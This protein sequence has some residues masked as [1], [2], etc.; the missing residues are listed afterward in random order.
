[1]KILVDADACPVKEIIVSLAKKNNLKVIMF[2]DTSHILSDD[3]SEVV[4]VDQSKDSADIKLVNQIEKNDI[5]VTQDYGVASMSLAKNAVALNQN[6]LIY[7]ND[8]IDQLMFE[9]FLSQKNRNAGKR[10]RGPKKRLPLDNIKFRES[11]NKLI[12]P[13]E[14]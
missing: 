3:Y 14:K 11:L 10:V 8:N 4:I 5:V 9:R 2:A 6:G 7:T 13:V 1:M 12:S